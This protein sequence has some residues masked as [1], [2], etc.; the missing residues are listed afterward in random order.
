M[1]G[2]DPGFYD[3]IRSHAA[4]DYP[5]FEILFGVTD[6]GDPAARRYRAPAARIPRLPDR[7]SCVVATD[8]PNA[9]AGVLAELAR[10]RPLPGA[11]GNDS[12][13]SVDPG[14]LEAVTAPLADPRVGLVDVSLSR[15]MA[16]S[17]AARLEALGIAT[18]FAPSVLVARLLGH[19][20]IRA[21][22]DHGL[23]RRDAARHRRLRTPSSITWPTIT[24]LGATSSELGYASSSR[25]SVVE[26]NLGA[27]S[28]ARRLA[29]PVA[30][31]AHHRV[32]RPGRLLGYVVT[33][34]TLWALVA[35][36]GGAMVGRRSRRWPC[37]SPPGWRWR[38]HPG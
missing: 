22:L 14:Y 10:Q 16:D 37:G 17:L 6:P 19:G 32:S 8:A 31:V 5:E 35:F 21:R 26:T 36:L 25:A 18:E 11:A 24:S 15:A 30:L 29:A 33:H 38:G 13:I 20:R 9:K 27:G 28:W 7:E 1:H 2:R 23:S 3:C 12:D 4:Q 34:A